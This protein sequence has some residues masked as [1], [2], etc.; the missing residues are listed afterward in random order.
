M[1]NEVALSAYPRSC[2][3]I[4]IAFISPP[5]VGQIAQHVLGLEMS[6]RHNGAG[7]SV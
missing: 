6:V 7:T 3:G 1:E 4:I 5:A 2:M